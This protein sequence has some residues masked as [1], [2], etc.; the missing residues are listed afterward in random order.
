MTYKQLEQQLEQ[1]LDTLAE[2]DEK[3]LAEYDLRD[4]LLKMADKAINKA[5][6]RNQKLEL[7]RIKK[8]LKNDDI[9]ETDILYII[10]YL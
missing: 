6:K 4:D 5:T 3:R 10:S 7:E 9:T 1:A 2:K 8:L